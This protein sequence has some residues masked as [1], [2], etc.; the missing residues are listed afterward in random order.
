MCI[1]DRDIADGYANDIAGI[2]LDDCSG[3]DQRQSKSVNDDAIVTIGHGTI[4][5]TNQTNPNA[6]TSD[7]SYLIWGNDGAAI[8][9][10]W[11]NN[12]VPIG[13]DS[14]AH[15]DRVWKINETSDITN[16]ILSVDVDDPAF[17]LPAI[18]VGS[19]GNYYILIDLSLIHI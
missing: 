3:L 5:S 18:P 6:F 14:Y 8:N 11:T 13:S 2:G 4:A 16:V 17:D 19:D 1:R 12:I 15:T 9:P 7:E 10:D